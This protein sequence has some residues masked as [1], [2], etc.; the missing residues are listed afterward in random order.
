MRT[1]IEG[2]IAAVFFG[3]KKEIPVITILFV[4]G[5]LAVAGKAQA[6]T[7]FLRPPRKMLEQ[8]RKAK[9]ASSLPR[10]R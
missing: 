8:M 4:L 6:Q 2:T 1:G 3:V 9:S 10:H 5:L 7:G